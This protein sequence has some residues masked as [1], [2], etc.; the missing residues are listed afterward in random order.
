MSDKQR[1]SYFLQ[2]QRIEKN[3]SHYLSGYKN[4]LLILYFHF[5]PERRE[6]FRGLFRT[7]SDWKGLQKC[8]SQIMD[9]FNL[10]SNMER[11]LFELRE[12]SIQESE[13]KKE[14]VTLE[15]LRKELRNREIRCFKNFYKDFN[16]ITHY[17]FGAVRLADGG[18]RPDLEVIQFDI[19]DS[20]ESEKLTYY[21]IFNPLRGGSWDGSY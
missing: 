16:L 14:I 7:I 3:N 8:Y 10:R 17:L 19:I 13:S 12:I 15:E 21:A 2:D 20:E 9:E 1:F 6:F 4:T 5:F 11:Q 18:L